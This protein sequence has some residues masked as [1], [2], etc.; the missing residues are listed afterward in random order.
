MDVQ[1]A[2]GP[3]VVG[4]LWWRV[5]QLRLAVPQWPGVRSHQQRGQLASV[6]AHLWHSSRLRT[7]GAVCGDDPSYGSPFNCG[8][9]LGSNNPGWTLGE[10]YESAAPTASAHAINQAHRT[11][12]A[13]AQTGTMSWPQPFP[14]RNAST[15]IPS[16][17]TMSIGSCNLAVHH[18]TPSLTMTCLPRSPAR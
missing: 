1:S 6:Q 4:H 3:L 18:A 16:G 17:S 13:V 2:L 8:Q 7:S 9:I 15:P 5:L 11:R 14:P 10:L 12:A